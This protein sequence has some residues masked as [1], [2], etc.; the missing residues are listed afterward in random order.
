MR[1]IQVANI[2]L[3]SRS[4]LARSNIQLQPEGFF[5]RFRFNLGVDE[6]LTELDIDRMQFPFQSWRRDLC[7]F[8]PAAKSTLGQERHQE[9][10]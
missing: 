7:R 5:F 3:L 6:L 10:R 4:D 8:L 1:G 9:E 2:D